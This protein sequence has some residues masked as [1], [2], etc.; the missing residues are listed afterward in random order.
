MSRLE[1]IS[2]PYR[3]LE[4]AKNI[5]NENDK[6]EVGNPN[7]LSDGDEKGKGEFNGSVGGLTDI[8]TRDKLMTKNKFNKNNEYCDATA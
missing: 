6:Y 5:Y 2:L 8:R 4:I 7:A 1:V 3:K